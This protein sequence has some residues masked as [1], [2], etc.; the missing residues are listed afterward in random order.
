LPSFGTG[1]WLDHR[2]PITQSRVENA[3]KGE[4]PKPRRL[5]R[6]IVMLRSKKMSDSAKSL[7]VFGIYSLMLGVT[8]MVTPNLLFGLVG[9]PATQEVWVRVAGMLLFALG[10]YYTL[11]ARN[12]LTEFFKWTVYT[13]G[14]VVFFF[15]VFVL[16]GFAKP[17]LILLGCVDLLFAVWTGLALRSEKKRQPNRAE[18]K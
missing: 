9:I 13:R 17:V 16:M 2:L 18:S 15:A 11:T 1:P 7:F 12:G 14:S 6:L 4:A 3:L 10:I 5:T 8:L